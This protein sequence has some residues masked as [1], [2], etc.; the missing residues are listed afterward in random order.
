MDDLIVERR[1][2]CLELVWH[3][4]ARV[5]NDS[6]LLPGR[7]SRTMLN[8][9]S[10]DPDHAVGRLDVVRGRESNSSRRRTAIFA[11]N[12]ETVRRSSTLDYLPC[13]NHERSE[14]SQG[15][16]PESSASEPG[17]IR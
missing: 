2:L 17:W 9:S 5:E 8:A 1:V 11:T 15:H 4:I 16:E 6:P 12:P 13:T 14:Q 3:A 10:V 7:A